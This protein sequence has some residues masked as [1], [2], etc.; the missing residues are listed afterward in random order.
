MKKLLSIKFKEIK[1]K[2]ID[3][4]RLS[5]SNDIYLDDFGYKQRSKFSSLI[6]FSLTG[7]ISFGILYAY[8]TKID[9]VVTAISICEP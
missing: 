9:E 4:I 6:I 7:T 8:L 1:R 5:R 3:Q 2:L